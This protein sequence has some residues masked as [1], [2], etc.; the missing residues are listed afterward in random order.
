MVIHSLLMKKE[1][2]AS[3]FLCKTEKKH[4]Q[5]RKKYYLCP[6]KADV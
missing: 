6:L 4:L 3:F 5:K 1:A 2:S